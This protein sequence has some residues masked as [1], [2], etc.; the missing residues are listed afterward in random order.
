MNDCRQQPFEEFDLQEFETLSYK[1]QYNASIDFLKEDFYKDIPQKHKELAKML[2]ADAVQMVEQGWYISDSLEYK[3]EFIPHIADNYEVKFDDGLTFTNRNQKFVWSGITEHNNEICAIV[4][5]E[6]VF[7]PFTNVSAEMS[8]KGRSLF[9]GEMWISL[10]DKQIEYATMFEDI[11]T[12]LQGVAF[13]QEQL[14][15]VQREI[16]FDKVK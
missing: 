7:Y 4:K 10:I 2:V 12:K 14:V 3:K 9:H 1:P 5:F 16:V 8:V 13:P 15:G 6:S 11:L